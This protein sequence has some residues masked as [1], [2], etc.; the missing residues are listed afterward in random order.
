[1]PVD[2]DGP[3]GGQIFRSSN[4]RAPGGP[5]PLDINVEFADRPEREVRNHRRNRRRTGAHSAEPAS[6]PPGRGGEEVP[7]STISPSGELVVQLRPVRTEEGYRSVYSDLTRPTIWTVLRTTSRVTGELLITFGLVVLLFAAYEV[8]GVGAKITEHQND[9]SN[10]LAQNWG[11]T[12]APSASAAPSV[13]TRPPMGGEAIARLYIPKIATEPWIVVQ[14]VT[15]ADIQYAPG[16]YPTTAMPG[17]IGNFS[18]A[19]HRTK[20]IFW[21]LDQLRVGDQIVVETRD[22][23]FVYTVTQSQIVLPTA[24]S[25]VAPVPNRPGVTPT[26]AM[27]TLTTCNPKW[28]NYQRLMIHGKL[29]SRQPHDAGPPAGAGGLTCT[30]G[31][32]ASCHSAFAGNSPAR[33]CSSPA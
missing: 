12:P 13:S 2:V 23:W 33:C 16:H 25:V 29:V 28:H 19:G 1:M 10:Q 30:R 17:Q 11:G 32:G 4:S 6:K 21:D 3:G 18:V 14:G 20:K 15:K 8:W 24:V 31:S 5:I 22:A 27:L 26:E 9:L 7:N